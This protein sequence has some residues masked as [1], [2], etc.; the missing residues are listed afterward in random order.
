LCIIVA[1]ELVGKLAASTPHIEYLQDGFR[2]TEITRILLSS[3]SRVLFDQHPRAFREVT[4]RSC[5]ALFDNWAKVKK[6]PKKLTLREA[7]N[8][9]NMQ[10][11]SILIL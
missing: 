11:K 3:A 5:G 8:K 4:E 10:Q 6:N 2:Q 1:D 9:I 7:C